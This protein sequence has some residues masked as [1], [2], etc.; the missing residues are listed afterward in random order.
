MRAELD[1]SDEA[2]FDLKQGEGGLVD[3]EFLLQ[4]LVLAHSQDH[5]ALLTPRNT[6]ELIAAVREA[7]LVAST[8]ADALSLAHTTLLARGLE[9][10]LDR[11]Q[12]RLPLDAAISDA[13]AAIRAAA[14][15]QAL[16]FT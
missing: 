2:A 1:R 7:G 12:R 9:C 4:A 3:L 6:P 8:A 10:T 5:P 11:R 14:E 13:R 15:A 16:D